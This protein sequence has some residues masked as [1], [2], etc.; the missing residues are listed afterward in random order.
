M[1]P[2]QSPGTLHLGALSGALLGI[3]S[4]PAPQ[5]LLGFVALAPLLAAIDRGAAVRTAGSAGFLAGV[6]QFGIGFGFVP[7]ATVGGGLALPVA[8]LV[9]V[10]ALALG[11]A[12]YAASLS[13][14]RRSSRLLPLSSLRGAGSLSSSCGPRT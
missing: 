10:T 13:W 8:Y 5:G 9:G 11:T 6:L 4:L 7:F 12:V 2:P 14:M 3:A 1:V